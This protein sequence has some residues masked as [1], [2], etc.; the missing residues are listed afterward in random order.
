MPDLEQLLK[1]LIQALDADTQSRIAII[2][3]QALSIWAYHYLLDELTGEEFAYLASDDLDFLGQRPEIE[4]CAEAW[5]VQAAYP[6]AFDPTPNSGLLLL[7]HDLRGNPIL[8]E[9][10]N[11][12][13]IV[14]DFLPLIHGVG[15]N[16]LANGFDR[17]LLDEQEQYAPR[18]LTPVLC[19]KS[20]LK[21]L[22]SLHYADELLP[23]E[24]VRARL[25][26]RVVRNYL[27]ALLETPGQKR[28]ALKLVNWL[29]DM[30]AESWC[31]QVAV[32]HDLDLFEAIPEKHIGFGER[33]YP[34]HYTAMRKK[35]LAKRNSFRER[36]NL[37][38]K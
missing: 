37:G 16:E 26:A 6:D 38:S 2:G 15:D 27:L 18:I 4:K 8:N 10:G 28:K 29:L 13:E 30:Y 1:D 11:R 32:R 24:R 23:R 35:I 33:F 7:D 36:T 14:I 21:N 31:I 34:D 22:Y 19:L 3:G 9:E 12:R 5:H 17:I 25:A 20:R